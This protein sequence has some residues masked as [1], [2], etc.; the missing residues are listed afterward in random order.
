VSRVTVPGGR[1][2][3]PS[4]C[5]VEAVDPS[6]L[7][8]D[9]RGWMERQPS[10]GSPGWLLAHADDGVMWGS[11]IDGVLE[12]TGDHFPAVSPPLRGETL[13]QARLF[14]PDAEVRAWRDGPRFRACRLEDFEDDTGE[15]FDERHVLWGTRVEA[16]SGP[17]TL[18]ADGGQGLRHA[19]PLTRVPPGGQGG[20]AAGR[21]LRLTVRH[22][23]GYDPEG[24]AFIRI[25]RLVRLDHA[26]G[27]K[28]Q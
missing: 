9:P 13:Q 7:A 4:G 2:L 27:G 23:I 12:L 24:Q 15:A 1:E 8:D 5:R 14:G 11:L 16:V 19:V 22:Y 17:F 28:R 21:P 26:K 6:G 18:V 20:D 10:V 3:L 25:S